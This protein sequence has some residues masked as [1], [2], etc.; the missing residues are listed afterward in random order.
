MR[1]FTRTIHG[2][3]GSVRPMQMGPGPLPNCVQCSHVQSTVLP[4]QPVQRMLF[5]LQNIRFMH[6]EHMHYEIVNCSF[7]IAEMRQRQ[8]G[9]GV[10]VWNSATHHINI[11]ES[12]STAPSQRA[13]LPLIRLGGNT[14]AWK[15]TI[16]EKV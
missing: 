11:N 3:I 13:S 5:R 10:E 15:T 9:S 16:Q 14:P 1:T 8:K 2:H 7:L 4:T 12:R 6:H